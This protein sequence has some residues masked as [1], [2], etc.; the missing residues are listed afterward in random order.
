MKQVALWSLL[1][2]GVL[3]MAL[4][5]GPSRRGVS[6]TPPRLVDHADA[7][8]LWAMPP[9]AINWDEVPGPDGVRVSVYLYLAEQAQPVLVKGSL[10]FMMYEGRRPHEGPETVQP[11]RT[12]QFTEQELLTHQMRGPAGWGYAA[13]LGWGRDVPKSAVITLLARYLPPAGPPV[14]S[15]PIVIPIPK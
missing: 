7:I 1:C 14:A 3:G 13:Q 10:E 11:F 2:A 15:S 12:W 8:E 5:C 6:R 4:G 9:A